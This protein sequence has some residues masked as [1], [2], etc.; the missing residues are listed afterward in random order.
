MTLQFSQLTELNRK[1]L[2]KMRLR[3]A[4]KTKSV[5]S[6]PGKDYQSENPA[7]MSLLGSVGQ[8]PDPDFQGLQPPNSMGMV[9]LVSPNDAGRIELSVS[10]QFDI[11]HRMIPDYKSMRQSLTY[12]DGEASSRQG[13]PEH[14]RRATVEFKDVALNI[15]LPADQNKWLSPEPGS[16]LEIAINETLDSFASD[17]MTF[18]RL[19]DNGKMRPKSMMEWDEDAI[20]DQTTFEQQV[21]E[22][23]FDESAA[24][25]VFDWRANLRVRARPAPPSLSNAKGAYLIEAFLENNVARTDAH[26]FG[27][28]KGAHLLDASLTLSVVSGNTHGLP[29]RLE[30][31]DYRYKDESTVPGYG[32]TT[33]VEKLDDKTFATNAMPISELSKITSPSIDELGMDQEPSF[34]ALSQDP[35]PILKSLV[36][37]IES[38][39]SDWRDFIVGLDQKGLVEEARISRKELALLTSEKISI[40]AGV[41]LIENHEHLRQCFCWMNEAMNNAFVLQKK[42]ISTWHLF[43]LGFIL[44]QITA[45]YER[46]CDEGQLSGHLNIA[47]VL[48]FPT[49]GG[50]TEAYLG[51]V[52]MAMLYDRLKG[53]TYGVTAWMKFPLRMLSVQQFQRLSYVVAQANRIRETVGERLGGHPF[54]IGYFTGGGTPRNI[55]SSYEHDRDSFLPNLNNED[56]KQWQFISDCPYCDADHSV[57]VRK[58]MTEGRIKHQCTNDQCWSN[59]EASKGVYGEGLHGELGIYASDEEVYR[60]IPTVIVG[61]IDKLATIAMNKR[62]LG[63]FGAST[64]FCPQHGF[65]MEGRCIHNALIQKGAGDYISERCANNSRQSKIKTHPV[66][67]MKSKGVSFVIQDELH[68]LQENTGNFDAHYETLLDA[69]QEGNGGRKP[70]ILSATAT[71]KGYEHHI[72]HLY[73][74]QARRFPAPGF[75]KGESFYSRI[76]LEDGQPLIRRLY[77]GILPLGG[78]SL[79]ERASAIASMRFLEVV[80]QMKDDLENHPQQALIEL[81]LEGAPSDELKRHLEDYMNACLIYINSIKGTSN[82]NRYLEDHQVNYHPEWS[83]RQLDGKS[84]LDEILDV[85][86]MIESKAPDVKTRQVIAT[87]VVSHGVDMS[88]LN[89]MVVGGWPKSI[90]EYM[91]SSARSGRVYPGIVLSVMNS[92][93]LFQNTV[94]ANFCDYHKFIDKLVETVPVNRFAPNLLQKTLPGIVTGVLFNWALAQPWGGDITKSAGKVRDA[95]K[96]NPSVRN[97]IKD[98]ILAALSVPESLIESGSFDQRVAEDFTRNLNNEVDKILLRLENLSS[99]YS[100]LY[101]IEAVGRLMGSKPMR[102]LRDIEIQAEVK[103]HLSDSHDLIESLEFRG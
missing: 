69:L 73:Q 22:H 17:P 90:A 32:I 87:S 85:I 49:G 48:W 93:L 62:Y 23:L 10:G 71:I 55:T 31:A 33:T 103:P 38:Y 25:A 82:V 26:W 4:D 100:E 58:S 43:Q 6:W 83:W 86:S 67:E 89:F 59:T 61:T 70:K 84:S 36:T 35:V 66:A 75:I 41:E 14:F 12:S 42:N 68:L 46:H 78:G 13:L 50:K 29:H 72:N 98:K 19:M 18:R 96:N 91:Q 28:F 99:S 51:I 15:N 92:K 95:L 80:D 9:V 16:A 37:A 34:V 94:F 47:E 44:S 65:S 45:I 63:F 40:N 81:G 24:G 11:F 39:E 79:V 76:H 20:E 74:K 102:S 27:I 97:L 2:Q 5:L 1:I 88:R 54:T 21:Y 30:P 56:L 77:A 8:A 64:H 57:V 101:V 52:V 53:R 3:L 60:Y 7:E